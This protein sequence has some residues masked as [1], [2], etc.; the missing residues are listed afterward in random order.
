MGF[1]SSGCALD[2]W[3]GADIDCGEDSLITKLGVARIDAV[4]GEEG[5]CFE[6]DGWDVDGAAE[7]F[8]LYHGACEFV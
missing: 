8:A 4:G 5:I 6:I 7:L 3:A 1:C 2:C